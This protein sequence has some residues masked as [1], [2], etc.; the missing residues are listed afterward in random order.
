MHVWHGAQEGPHQGMLGSAPFGHHLNQHYYHTPGA[1]STGVTTPRH[2]WQCP[3]WPSSSQPT[4]LPHT[5]GM[6]HRSDHTKARLAVPL[7]AII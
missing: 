4:L 6:E 2:A 7:L 1:W 3:F 5:W